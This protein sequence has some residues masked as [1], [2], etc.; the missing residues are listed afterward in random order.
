MTQLRI[1]FKGR[2]EVQTFSGARIEAMGDGVQLAL[3]L[4]R[5]VR[6]LRQVLAQ[7]PVG[8][9]VGAAR[10]RVFVRR[11]GLGETPGAGVAAVQ[12]VDDRFLPGCCPGGDH[13]VWHPSHLQYRSR[14][15]VHQPGVHRITERPR[16]PDQHGRERLLAR[17]RVRGTT[18][19]KHQMRAGISTRLRVRQRCQE[20]IRHLLCILQPEKNAPGTCRQNTR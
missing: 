6:A 3:R 7:Q 20:R 12:R 11:P 1:N 9:F 5:Q 13:P 2:G 14:V 15:P 8:V 18:L 4:L 10:L 16:H 17:Q 19:E